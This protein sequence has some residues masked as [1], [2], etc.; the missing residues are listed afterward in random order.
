MTPKELNESLLSSFPEL[1]GEFEKYTSWQDG[2]DTGSILVVEDIFVKY[3]CQL[4]EI[5]DDAKL[6]Q[7]FGFMEKLLNSGDHYA[8]NV[9]EVAFIESLKASKYS[10]MSESYFGPNS[11]VVFKILKY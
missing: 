1:K 3:V 10:S 2:I 6:H 8:E 11:L 5:G 7:T 9:V 4:F